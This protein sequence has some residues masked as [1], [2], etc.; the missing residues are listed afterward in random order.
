MKQKQYIDAL[1]KALK[2]TDNQNRENILLEIKGLI[3]ELSINESIEERF[4]SPTELAKQYLKDEPIK[5]SAGKKAMSFGKKLFLV[6]GIGITV[7]IA[8]L[9]LTAW[10]FSKDKFDYSDMSS[11]YLDI[12]DVNWHSI[13]WKS[14]MKLEV[15]QGRAVVY[16]HNASDIKWNC[17]GDQNL[18][19]TTNN[20]LIVRHDEC[21]LFLPKQVVGIEV[22]QSDLVIVKPQASVNIVVNQGKLRIAQNG[23]EYKF[24]VNATRGK[25]GDFTSHRDALITIS[26]KANEANIEAYEY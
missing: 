26:V 22:K 14:D 23:E 10:Y 12:T 1:N 21:L 8:G 3:N 19:P 15:E 2:S 24:E 16:W 17:R 5:A 18:K 20:A 7:L 4:G 9:A 13:D 11:K 25:V 6:I